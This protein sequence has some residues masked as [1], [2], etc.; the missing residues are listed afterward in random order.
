M[1]ISSSAPPRS[2]FD[3]C[4]IHV[5][6]D[7]YITA[8][9]TP[10]EQD[11]GYVFADCR[12]TGEEGVKTYLG[13]PW[14]DFAKTIFLRTEMSD[15]VRPAGW[16]NWNKPQAELTT[17]YAESGSTG[18]GANDAARVTLGPAAHGGS[19]RGSH[20]GGRA[21]RHGWLEPGCAMKISSYLERRRDYQSRGLPAARLVPR[22][23][24]R[25]SS[26]FKLVALLG[27]L[28]SLV[29]GPALGA[30]N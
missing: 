11:H 25:P 26:L 6:A 21:R 13:R 27:S 12:I 8:A 30:G 4:H 18:P 29:G 22:G 20:P 19:G 16:H 28:L 7:G 10:K 15:A 5:L 17:F 3:R 24:G 23:T 14:R 1:W 9:S 2:Y